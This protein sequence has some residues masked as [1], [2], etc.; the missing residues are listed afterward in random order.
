M[1]MDRDGMARSWG[2]ALSMTSGANQFSYEPKGTMVK[3]MHGGIPAQNGIIAAQLAEIGV[4]YRVRDVDLEAEAQRDASYASVNPQRKVPALVT[5]LGETLTES[6][7]ILLTL[8]Q[9]HP[10]AALLPTEDTERARALR[11]LLFL[12]SEIYPIVEINDYP[13]RFRADGSD[14][15]TR[16]RAR[17]IW[18]TR[19]RLLADGIAGEPWL[20]D[21]CPLWD[22]CRI[23]T[24]TIDD[25]TRRSTQAPR[26][27]THRT[28]KPLGRIEIV[29]HQR[30]DRRARRDLGQQPLLRLFRGGVNECA[31]GHHG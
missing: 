10:D 4:A 7:A 2:L 16:E 18:R 12:A 17:E 15:A 9:R 31:S 29:E 26:I 20:R 8:D 13:E 14:E 1:G 5:P 24:Y 27:G 11:W 19:W 3:R 30:R 28:A 21:I 22:P 6:V 25:E 23:D